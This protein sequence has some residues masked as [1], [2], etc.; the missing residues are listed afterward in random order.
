MLLLLSHARIFRDIYKK[1]NRDV[2]WTYMDIYNRFAITAEDKFLDA[3]RFSEWLDGWKDVGHFIA[4]R[5][6]E[7]GML[8]AAIF[9]MPSATTYWAQNVASIAI[10]YDTTFN[11]NRL[12]LKLGLITAVDNEGN[13]I[14][15]FVTVVAHQDKDTF[16]WIFEQLLSA[17]RVPPRIIFTDSD[18]AMATAIKTVLGTTTHLLCTWHLSLNLITNLKGVAGSNMEKIKK[19]YWQICKESDYNERLNF[20][21]DFAELIALLPNVDAAKNPEGAK[22]REAALTWLGT[23]KARKEQ[24]AARWCWSHLTIGMNYYYYSYNEVCITTSTQ[25]INNNF[26]YLVG[27]HSTQ[28]SESVH[29]VEKKETSVSMLWTNLA[30]TLVDYAADVDKKQQ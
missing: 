20:D 22:K 10:L 21:R 7:Y 13:T 6:N 5:L 25:I 1:Q 17:M 16:T 18:P 14:I 2:T 12:G 30:N 29:I 19:K 3:S 26:C 28:R 9:S 24:W 4:S 15:L 27:V 11:T 23:L 8:D